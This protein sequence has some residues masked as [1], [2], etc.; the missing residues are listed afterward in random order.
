MG[1]DPATV[2]RCAD[3]LVAAWYSEQDKYDFSGQSKVVNSGALSLSLS[4]SLSVSPR[5][6][7]L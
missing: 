6:S 4:L 7:Y 2:E 3:E 5:L 1:A